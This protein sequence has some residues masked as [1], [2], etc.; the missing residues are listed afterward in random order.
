MCKID[1]K[2]A[3]FNVPLN[4]QSK[5]LIRFLW[6]GN[7]YKFTVC[8]GKVLCVCVCVCVGVCVCVCV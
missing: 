7:L 5:H 8:V 2:G 4:P 1:L 6:K 3:Y